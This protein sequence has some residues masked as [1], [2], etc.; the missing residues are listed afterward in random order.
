MRTSLRP[1]I[2]CGTVACYIKPYTLIFPTLKKKKS[3]NNFITNRKAEMEIKNYTGL[4]LP[5][6]AGVPQGSAISPTL[7]TTNISDLPQPAIDFIN[8]Q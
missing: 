5:L 2:Q 4:T 1:S 7:Y 6:T 8:I 3:L